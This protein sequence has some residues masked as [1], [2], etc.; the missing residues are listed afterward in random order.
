[1]IDTGIPFE[2]TSN[3]V[4]KLDLDRAL[5]LVEF[6]YKGN[7]YTRSVFASYPDRCI[8]IRFTVEGEA[9]QD[10]ALSFASPNAF[11]PRM[12]KGDLVIQGEVAD[13]GLPVDAR[14]RVLQEGGRVE[15]GDK[16]V[17]V[18][19][20]RSV[21]F[22]LSADTGFD[23][24]QPDLVG[25][26]RAAELQRVIDAA[27]AKGYAALLAELKEWLAQYDAPLPYKNAQPVGG[28]RLPGADRVPDVLK[29]Q[30]AGRRI[31]VLVETG[32]DKSKVIVAKL[33]YTTNGSE[34]F[35]YKKVRE[36]WFEAPAEISGGTVSAIAPPGMTHGV[37]YLRA[38][39][40][41]IKSLDVPEAKLPVM[42]QFVTKKW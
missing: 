14:V 16:S 21:T 34:L 29:R 33:I 35:W 37:F 18:K 41:A 15:A 40:N 24:D 9:R 36:E 31:E 26:G 39:R 2:E 17:A 28:A 13:S 27:A 30:S 22:L 8:V 25:E 1:M 32:E 5:H 4:R 11:I 38:L 19:G 42:N 10:L 7:H 12:E 23:F 20:A 6:D 3:Y